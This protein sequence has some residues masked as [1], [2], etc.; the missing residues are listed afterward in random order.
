MLVTSI[1]FFFHNVFKTL[2]PPVHPKSSLC[3]K[4]LNVKCLRPMAVKKPV[5]LPQNLEFFSSAWRVFRKHDGGKKEKVLVTSI[6][7]FYA[8]AS[9]DQGL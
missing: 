9:I 7:F 8:P 6:F 2:F 1:F 5:T 4:G 3:G